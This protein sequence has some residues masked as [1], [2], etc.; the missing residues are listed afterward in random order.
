LTAKNS[1]RLHNLLF[2]FISSLSIISQNHTGQCLNIDPSMSTCGMLRSP[3]EI[4]QL[5]HDLAL[6]LGFS[7][8]QAETLAEPY[9]NYIENRHTGDGALD[10]FLRL[11]IKVVLHFQE[12][13]TATATEKAT[14]TKSSPTINSVQAFID[15]L[16]QYSD[17]DYFANTKESSNLRKELV[18]DTVL[19]ILGVWVAM[20]SY[21]VQLPGGYRQIQRAYFLKSGNGKGK[22]FQQ[23]LDGRFPDLLNGSGLLPSPN[24]CQDAPF[25]MIANSQTTHSSF[26]YN[27]AQ[28]MPFIGAA[29]NCHSQYG[30]NGLNSTLPS[31][32]RA[33]LLHTRIDDLESLSIK[34][35]KLN[36]YNLSSLGGV[37]IHWTIN[38]S[39]H[40]LLSRFAGRDVLEVFA[41]PCILKGGAKSLRAAG[42]PRDLIHEV[43]E[44]YSLL[45]NT[46]DVRHIHGQL[47]KAACLRWLCWCR[48]CSFHRLREKELRSLRKSK[49]FPFGRRS[50]R[51]N[52]KSEYDPFLEELMRNLGPGDWCFEL[53][54][55]LWDR[56]VALEEHLGNSK[57]WNFWVL[58]RDRRDTLQFWTFL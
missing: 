1:L 17:G 19:Y 50:L 39:R 9:L 16:C 45:F 25:P 34:S 36:A 31:I 13:T 21:F 49:N 27:Q 32:T 52:A 38:F 26:T 56:I 28:R 35:S 42:V 18:T 57:P 14:G 22:E 48:A 33:A 20:L 40:M 12:E 29:A 37:R 2:D 58:L 11:F 44:S 30:N 46:T 51:S 8:H 47:V 7:E 15:H 6:A 53:F 10:G 23:A 5:R 3:S 24:D 41:L 4:P 43:Q 55:H 54:P